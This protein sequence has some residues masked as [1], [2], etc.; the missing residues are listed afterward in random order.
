MSVRLA[1]RATERPACGRAATPAERARGLGVDLVTEAPIST[2]PRRTLPGVE[3]DV[4]LSG[5]AATSAIFRAM[6]ARTGVRWLLPTA[7]VTSAVVTLAAGGCQEPTQIRLHV[8]TDLSCERLRNA[9]LVV[10][11]SGF[12]LVERVNAEGELAFAHTQPGPDGLCRPGADGK[13]NEIGMTVLVPADRDDVPVAVQIVLGVDQSVAPARCVAGDQSCV[14]ASRSLR[15]V[16]HRTLDVPVKL[17]EVC[18][19]VVCDPG[20]TCYDAGKCV[21]DGVACDAGSC[22]LTDPGTPQGGQRCLRPD[23]C[24]GG[25]GAAGSGGGG[26]AGG[27]SGGASGAGGQGG[28][29]AGGGSDGG[30]SGAAGQGGGGEGGAPPLPTNLEL[31]LKADAGVTAVDTRVSQW[32]DQS[33]NGH[34]ASMADAAKQPFLVDSQLNGKPVVRFAGAESLRFAANVQANNFTF[35]VVGKNNRPD[36]AFNLILGPSGGR[37]NQLRWESGSV[38]L[39]TLQSSP[40]VTSNVGN[41]KIY[42]QLA[43]SYDGSTFSFFRDGTPQSS[44]ALQTSEVWAFG[45]VGAWYSEYFALADMAEIMV[46]N[47]ALSDAE[48][49]TVGTYLGGKYNLLPPASASAV[50]LPP[51][52]PKPSP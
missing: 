38:V 46:Y 43:G 48:R 14:S 6:N 28:G 17:F 50:V 12:N 26:A 37:N 52:V 21:S 3:G 24:V 16:P 25:A 29:G 49:T 44:Q 7:V 45:Q 10:G 27:G 30:A 8:T 42:H 15:Y 11:G 20:S 5:A 33:G 35:F 32:A 9:A 36:E 2:M 40:N 4:F 13:N 31:W 51:S 34:H 18:L 39:F 22:Q 23:G 19:G 41:T 1:E 47:R